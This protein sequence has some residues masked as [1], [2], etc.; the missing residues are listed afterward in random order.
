M[1]LLNHMDKIK[2]QFIGI[3]DIPNKK[4]D[5]I[6]RG[7]KVRWLASGDGYQSDESLSFHD[8]NIVFINYPKKLPYPSEPTGFMDYI[9][10]GGIVV[11]FLG[12]SENYPWWDEL[13]GIPTGRGDSVVPN[14]DHWLKT[15]LKKY[16][17]V[18]Y[19]LIEPLSYFYQEEPPI[20]LHF[21]NVGTAVSGKCVSSIV[22]YGKG[23]LI[24]LPIL[25]K[26]PEELIRELIDGIKEN[27][28]RKSM[29]LISEP[30]PQWIEKWNLH[31]ELKLKDEMDNLKNEM[32]VI[33]KKAYEI[34]K[35][36]E[37]YGLLKKILYSQGKEL[38]SSIHLILKEMGFIADLKEDEGR[39]DIEINFNSFFAIVEAKGLK[40]YANNSDL[41]QLLD[42][43][44]T[45]SET[46]PEVKGV[47]IINH[48]RDKEPSERDMPYSQGAI[49]LAERNAFCLLTT[50]DL[51]KMYNLLLDGKITINQIIDL[52]KT[53][54]GLCD[55]GKLM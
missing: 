10:S 42:Y 12:P 4:D 5:E 31:P 20:N 22:H 35:K 44:V 49:T 45:T 23:K 32:H 16:P 43:Y 25:E 40:G 26:I 9:F 52:F 15:I 54:K 28:F 13:L 38:S 41:R 48:F 19:C 39:Q 17:F 51:F 11:L 37:W 8:Y 36:Q 27:Y 34:E 21:E 29:I 14:P 24:L 1:A 55:V 2:V 33:I 47:F 46:N 6:L 53:T 50:V 7:R 30:K 3:K 18:W